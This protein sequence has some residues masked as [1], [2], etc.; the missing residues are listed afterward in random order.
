M[1]II[2]DT[3]VHLYPGYDLTKAF[4][5][6]Q[7][8]L[9]KLLPSAEE[10]ILYLTERSECALYEEILAGALGNSFSTK[11]LSSEVM[12]LENDDL[13]VSLVLVRG[14][15]VAT[16]ERLEVLGLACST[17]VQDRIPLSEAIDKIVESGGVPVLNWAP[18]KWWFK[19]GQFVRRELQRNSSRGVLVGDVS[20]RPLG[21]PLPRLFRVAQ[22][23]GIGM[24]AGSDPLPFAGEEERIG[25]YGIM[26]EQNFLETSASESVHNIL[27]SAD[28]SL[29][30]SRGSL[31]SVGIRLRENQRVR[32][33]GLK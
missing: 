27:N 10:R 33:E 14:I 19:R 21:Y 17:R 7:K 24:I 30:G 25:S 11:E 13:N 26:S 16:L 18:G 2:A 28:L 29:V 4:C 9:S 20:L 6:A 32:R 1:S 5:F 12:R 3:H 8:N 31:V 15:Q 23:Q 22:E